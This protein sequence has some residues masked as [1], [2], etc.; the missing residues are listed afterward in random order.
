MDTINVFW[1]IAIQLGLT[2]KMVSNKVIMIR[3]D[4]FIVQTAQ[5]SI[6]RMQ[7]KLDTLD[8]FNWLKSTV[9]VFHQ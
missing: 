7:N 6:F 8:E 2:N 1:I 3:E 9:G 4:L 5:G